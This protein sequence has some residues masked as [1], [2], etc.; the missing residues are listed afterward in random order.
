MDKLIIQA[1]YVQYWKCIL[2]HFLFFPRPSTIKLDVT[3]ETRKF[4][5]NIV[6]FLK[7]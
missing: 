4:T 6:I 3:Q 1:A 2:S 5:R 7:F